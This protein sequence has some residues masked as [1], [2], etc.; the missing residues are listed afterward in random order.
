VAENLEFINGLTERMSNI[1]GQ[2]KTFARKSNSR[3]EPV[4]LVDVIERVLLFMGPQLD[5]NG[6]RLIKDLPAGGQAIVPGNAMQLE[7]VMTN[8]IDNGLDAMK[9]VPGQKCLRIYLVLEGDQALVSCHDSGPGISAEAQELLFDPFYTTKDI[10]EGLGLGLSISYGIV[11]EMGG[12]VTAE[13]HPEG[14]ALFSLRLPLAESL[15]TNSEE[16]SK[17]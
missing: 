7:Q 17:E 13:N 12:T 3:L 4:D 6:V 15:N 10:G 9:T 1:T 5:A 8:L 14:G 11:R 2:L 16:G